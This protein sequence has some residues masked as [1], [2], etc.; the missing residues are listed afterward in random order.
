[1]SLALFSSRRRIIAAPP[2]GPSGFAPNLPSGMILAADTNFVTPRPNNAIIDGW[3]LDSGNLPFTLGGQPNTSYQRVEDATS[4]HGGVV[5]RMN[6]PDGHNGNGGSFVMLHYG[7]PVNNVRELY[8]YCRTRFSAGY[9]VHTNG[10]TEKFWYPT[11]SNGGPFN[12]PVIQWG[13]VLNNGVPPFR[14]GT[15]H[16]NEAGEAFMSQPEFQADFNFQRE[17]FYDIEI[18]QR[19]GSH[20]PALSPT[21]MNADGFTRIWVN[22]NLVFDFQAHRATGS[23]ANAQV[24]YQWPRLASTRG[25]G[26]SG[27]VAPFGGMWREFDRVAVHYR[28]E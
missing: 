5:G 1:M 23:S 2:S 10:F 4:I 13:T 21:F 22:G 24:T 18:H 20:N 7:L 25:G 28:P 19:L 14:L 12:A 9:V 6:F 26:T 17:T 8:F 15:L 27:V 16:F 3:S 11:V